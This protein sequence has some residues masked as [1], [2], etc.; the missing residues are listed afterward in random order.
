M[1]L[2]SLQDVRESKGK[3]QG[4]I[5]QINIRIANLEQQLQ[6]QQSDLGVFSEKT[7]LQQQMLALLQSSQGIRQEVPSLPA[8]SKL[9]R[10][11]VK[12]K[13]QTDRANKSYT[14]K[15]NN[16][17]QTASSRDTTVANS[18]SLDEKNSYTAAYLAYKSERYDDAI[19]AF[20][21][22]LQ[23]YPDGELSDPSYYWLAESLLAQKSYAQ[24]LEA[25]NIYTSKYPESGKL[26]VAM[27]GTARSQAALN[28]TRLAKASLQALI[29]QFPASTA[30]DKARKFLV[31]LA[32]PAASKVTRNK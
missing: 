28:A 19:Q 3:L 32:S 31:T 30:A 17:T 14:K 11:S 27:L 10:A 22:L 4:Q 5:E 18:S 29:Q 7:N 26:A 12:K 16:I 9:V 23:H 13:V 20:Q 8:V 2:L 1:V 6:Q 21:T 24:A 25:F 15:T